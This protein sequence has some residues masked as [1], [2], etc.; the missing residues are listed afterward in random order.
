MFFHDPFGRSDAESLYNYGQDTQQES[1]YMYFFD[2]EPI[3]LDLHMSTFDDVVRRNLDICWPHQTPGSIVTSEQHSEFVE[4]ICN[5]YGWRSHYYFFHGW[6]SLDWFRGYDRTF[7]MPDPKDRK[8][9]KSFIS[10]NRIVGGKRDHRIILMYKL[11]K[12]KINNAHISFPGICP[13]EG[14]HITSLVHKWHDQYPDMPETFAAQNLP[15]NFQGETDHPMH[16]CWLSLFDQCAET[17]AYVVTETVQQGNRHHLTEKTFKPIC[18]QM[19]FV[20]ASTQ[21]SLDYLKS[22]GFRTFNHVW[23]ESYDHESDDHRRIEMIAHILKSLD[24]C[25]PAELHSIYRHTYETVVWNYQHFY[26]GDFERLLW[27]ELQHMM[28]DMKQT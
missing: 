21:G 7:L 14:T 1:N 15:W 16:S 8:I 22:Y 5:T 4:S 27:K 17:C 13:A 25:S 26:G 11:F 12:K 3:H 19:P 20:L 24:D 9:T 28:Q 6:A 10:A 18:L 23:D 2:Q